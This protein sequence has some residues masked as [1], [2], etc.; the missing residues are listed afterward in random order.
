[1]SALTI[2]PA[3]GIP[4]VEARVYRNVS[5]TTGLASYAN[6]IGDPDMAMLVEPQG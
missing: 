3:P 1:M 4:P 5:S 2:C 6:R